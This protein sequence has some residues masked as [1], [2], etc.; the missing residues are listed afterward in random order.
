MYVCSLMHYVLKTTRLDTKM[1]LVFISKCWDYRWLTNNSFC[2]FIFFNINVHYLC[3]TDLYNAWKLLIVFLFSILKSI[4]SKI[5]NPEHS[6][7]PSSASTPF[8]FPR[9]RPNPLKIFVLIFVSISSLSNHF[10]TVLVLL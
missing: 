7:F 6:W 4:L 2:K 3:K 8:L 1:L 9:F 10:Q 5:T